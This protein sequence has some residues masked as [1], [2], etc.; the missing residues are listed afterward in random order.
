MA[1]RDRPAEVGTPVILVNQEAIQTERDSL[2][3]GRRS[4]DGQDT[5]TEPVSP[6][7]QLPSS[8]HAVPVRAQGQG[9]ENSLLVCDAGLF[10]QGCH[11]KC[12]Q[13]W[14]LK[15]IHLLSF[16]AWGPAVK[17]SGAALPAE[18]QGGGRGG[19]L[20]LPLPDSSSS[21]APW[22]PLGVWTLPHPPPLLHFI[23]SPRLSVCP[24]SQGHQPSDGGPA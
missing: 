18:A 8:S 13:D 21:R 3:S 23:P 11:D 14:W 1:S 10:S 20:S 22:A 5:N 15:M 7:S 9:E 17:V 6:C 16:A 2:G 19:G 12:T 4:L 24:L